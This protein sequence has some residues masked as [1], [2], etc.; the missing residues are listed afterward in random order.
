MLRS[1]LSAACRDGRMGE[2]GKK[3]AGIK[4]VMREAPTA[5]AAFE[6]PLA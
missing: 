6:G 1:L 5:W 2:H 4:V 3:L